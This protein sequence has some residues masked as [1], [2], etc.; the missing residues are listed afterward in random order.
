M[1]LAFLCCHLF[2]IFRNRRLLRHYTAHFEHSLTNLWPNLAVHVKSPLLFYY[3]LAA[4]PSLDLG[5]AEQVSRKLG[6]PHLIED[7]R[8]PK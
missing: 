6:A 5:Y 7:V 2:H 4:I 8:Q 1:L 3:V